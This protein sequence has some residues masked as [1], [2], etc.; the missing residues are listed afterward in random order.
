M[1]RTHRCAE[2]VLP[3]F[4]VLKISFL[5]WNA[6]GG[7]P[8]WCVCVCVFG[9]IK[10]WQLL[11]GPLGRQWISIP[12][13]LLFTFLLPACTIQAGRWLPA[14]SHQE[15]V[16]SC[17]SGPWDRGGNPRL[18]FLAREKCFVLCLWTLCLLPFAFSSVP[19]PPGLHMTQTPVLKPPT[20]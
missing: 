5:L 9:K 2:V 3:C 19:W 10:H 20:S 13:P 17:S 4:A 12:K 11:A 14:R 7:E 6:G 18:V 16:M 15:A 1:N 8:W